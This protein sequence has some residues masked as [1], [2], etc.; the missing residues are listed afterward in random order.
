[1][2]TGH[3][4]IA[5]ILIAVLAIVGLTLIV[6]APD[7]GPSESDSGC[8]QF[9]LTPVLFVHGSG[10]SSRSWHP[11][12]RHFQSS[13]YPEAYLL[14]VELEPNDGDNIR[15]AEEQIT[16]A[17]QRLERAAETAS[18]RSGCS[19]ATPDRIAIV[20]HSMGSVSGRWYA[21]RIAPENVSALITLAGSNHGTDE[22]CELSGEGDAQMCPAFSDDEQ[23]NRVQTELNGT[24][25]RPADETPFGPGPDSDPSL[26]VRPDAERRILYVTVYL[27]PDRWIR[28]TKSALLDGA[29][30][31]TVATL[32]DGY[33]VVETAPGNYRFTGDTNHDELPEHPQIS[34]FVH[35]I[36]T[37]WID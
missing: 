10:L 12:I 27:D 25:S 20:A 14:A 31:G 22:L 4:R 3:A 29:G 8:S 35:L 7:P 9:S 34:R 16:D 19:G 18:D 36:L 2:D 21:T 5:V 13:G 26:S 33:D 23:R 24:S 17:V 11:M 6:P 30:L 32:P 1:M 28:P 15:A 37:N